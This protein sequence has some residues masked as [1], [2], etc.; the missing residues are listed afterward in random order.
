MSAKWGHKVRENC[1][2]KVKLSSQ[3]HCEAETGVLVFF[4]PAMCGLN[5]LSEYP[6]YIEICLCV[7]EASPLKC[8]VAPAGPVFSPSSS[9]SSY[10][11]TVL[12]LF[13]GINL[14]IAG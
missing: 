2:Q 12:R 11:L 8:V 1:K 6:I 5:K 4:E 9:S 7:V 13:L 3:R 10:L 14:W